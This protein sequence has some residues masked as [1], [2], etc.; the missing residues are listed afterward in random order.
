MH[1]YAS[2]GSPYDVAVP[3]F[4]TV[5]VDVPVDQM[6][7][8]AVTAARPQLAADATKL[9]VGTSI[10]TAALTLFGVYALSNSGALRQ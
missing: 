3:G 2:L 4:G 5:T 10:L 6:A 7:R 8:D 9:V 1:P